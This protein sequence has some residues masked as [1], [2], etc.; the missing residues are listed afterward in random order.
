MSAPQS[1]DHRLEVAS[2]CAEAGAAHWENPVPS[3]QRLTDTGPASP[4]L[5]RTK[6]L[7]PL[8]SDSARPVPER[9]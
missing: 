2:A 1:P 7:H 3:T 4:D 8:P 5:T 6:A 9:W